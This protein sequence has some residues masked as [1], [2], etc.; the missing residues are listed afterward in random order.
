MNLCNSISLQ[1]KA[2]FLDLGK[3]IPKS[4]GELPGIKM[5][6]E[7]RLALGVNGLNAYNN[8]AIVPGAPLIRASS[9]IPKEYVGMHLFLIRRDPEESRIYSYTGRAAILIDPVTVAPKER[10]IL[11]FFMKEIVAEALISQIEGFDPKDQPLAFDKNFISQV[12]EEKKDIQR[13]IERQVYPERA[14]RM[15]KLPDV[16]APETDDWKVGMF[17]SNRITLFFVA[18]LAL[19]LS[20]FA[21]R[22]LRIGLNR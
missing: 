2:E 14:P 4:W 15:K 19:V 12:V 17:E 7:G 9:G 6:Q 22:K 5:I 3:D 1:I 16:E 20:Y 11:S 13:E 18:S 10:R 8:F 21:Y